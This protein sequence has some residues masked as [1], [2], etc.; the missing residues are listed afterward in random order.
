MKDLTQKDF[1]GLKKLIK[2][3]QVG[4]CWL[5]NLVYVFNMFVC[6][7]IKVHGHSWNQ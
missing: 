3:I 5:F 2:Q 4:G 1:D 6:R 7:H